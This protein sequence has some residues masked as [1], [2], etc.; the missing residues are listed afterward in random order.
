MPHKR[1]PEGSEHL[2]TLARLVRANA[3]V[4]T[5]GVAQQHERDGRGW[6]AE[7]V[8]WPEACLLAAAAL[9]TAIGLL[10]G[11]TVDAAAMRRNLERD[12]GYPV[13]ERVLA[14]LATRMG[15]RRAWQRLQEAFAGR[16]RADR[17]SGAG[18]R[19]AVRRG[20]GRGADRAAGYRFVPG[21]GRPGGRAGPGRPG[22]RAAGMAMTASPARI[23]PAGMDVTASPA[24]FRLATLP[25]PLVGAPHLAEELGIGALY[26]KRDD[27]TGFALAGN[28]ARPLEFLL[29]AAIADGA[30]T[31]VT[32]GAAGSNFC[33]AT[34]A[35]ALRAGLRCELVIAG[36]ARPRSATV[37]ALD[38]AMSWGASVR[39]TGAAERES[40]DAGLP[41]AVAEL[42]AKPSLEPRLPDTA[43]RSHRD[44]RGRLRAGRARAARAAR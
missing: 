31:L 4:M 12:G 39:W 22:R 15:A 43:G 25:T 8:A 32:G 10:S 24:R 41:E 17:R 44:R 9:Q 40:V 6:K 29:A 7:W 30:D 19:G 3:A 21:D 36:D 14:R 34:A 42:T 37:P 20:R 18:G 13:S 16:D 1:N 33:A 11:L 27:L 26:V 35:A 2:D 38:L 28:K 5:E 23:R